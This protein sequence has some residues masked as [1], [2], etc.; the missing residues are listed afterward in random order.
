MMDK[1]WVNLELVKNPVLS[2]ILRSLASSGKCTVAVMD[3]KSNKLI[4]L[5]KMST[6]A[7]GWNHT[8]SDHS[9]YNDYKVYSDYGHT[10][11]TE[12]DVYGDYTDHNLNPHW[13]SVCRR[14][15]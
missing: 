2:K 6:H 15:V 3:S 5:R 12:Y 10:D 13:R 1:Y 8:D 9:R 4:T 7:D 11:Y 14:R